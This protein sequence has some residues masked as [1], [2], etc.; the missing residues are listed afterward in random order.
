MREPVLVVHRL[1]IL[2]RHFGEERWTRQEQVF[3]VQL[4]GFADR[5]QYSVLHLSAIT[6]TSDLQSNKKY[7]ISK[8]EKY[9]FIYE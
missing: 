7:C 8:R 6:Y 4:E 1:S 9:E 2:R 3:L 5:I